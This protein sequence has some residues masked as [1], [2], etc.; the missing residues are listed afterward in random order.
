M[1][2]HVFAAFFLLLALTVSGLLINGHFLETPDVALNRGVSQVSAAAKPGKTLR[3]FAS[4]NELERFLRDFAKKNELRRA[5]MK[6][7]AANSNSATPLADSSV[8]SEKAEMDGESVT[9]TQHAGVDEGGIVKLHGNH[10]IILRRGR[11][12]TVA[13]G[14]GSLKPVSAIDAFPADGDPGGTWYDEMLVFRDTIAVIGYSYSRGG[15]EVGLFNIDSFGNLKYRSTYHLR[16]NDYYSS[17]NYASRLVDGKL[18]FYT[19]Q[20]LWIDPKNPTANFPALRKWHRGAKNDE[21]QNIV[22]ATRVYRPAREISDSYGLALHTVTVCDLNSEDFRCEGTGVIGPAGRVFYVS[23][24][25]VYVWTSDWRRRGDRQEMTS[26]LYKM[27]LD[28]GAPQA[29]GVAGSPVDQFSFLESDDN[30]LNVLVRS[31]SGGEA[32][33]RSEVS[34]GD[35][36][37]LRIPVWSFS[38]GTKNASSWNYKPLPT[39]EG[40]TL[41][42]RFVGDHLLYGTGNSWGR[43]V[44]GGSEI[45][46]VRWATGETTELPLEH[47][48]DRIEA[49]G[50]DAVVVGTRGNDL[51]FSPVRLGREPS[52]RNSYVRQNAAQGELRSHGFFYKPDGKDSGTLGLPIADQGRPGY[53]H[54]FEGSAS[55]LFVRNNALKLDEIGTLASRDTKQNDDNCKA[56]CVDWYGNARP[57]FIRG[58]V[59]AL[60]GYEIVEGA[61]S[62]NAIRE[63]RRT[64]FSPGYAKYARVGK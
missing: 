12:F 1:K 15:T 22:A 50:K 3:A 24:K 48:V 59:F 16:S 2:N 62:G 39:A 26:M 64:N 63:T 52:V 42:N 53:K 13:I 17:R 10:L 46:A 28:G 56:S 34:K 33:W 58:R 21:F 5:E 4:Q 27:P 49:L 19:P 45:Y 25:S 31:E 36:A 9:N 54:L 6:S 41:Q 20:Y 51:Y 60:L 43:Q 47:S 38:D 32:M 23:P 8:A 37:L 35:T 7:G 14:S 44:K 18:I 30:H 61:L 40:Y 29:L 11:L 55:V 57:L